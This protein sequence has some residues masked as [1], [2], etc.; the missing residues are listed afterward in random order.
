VARVVSIVIVVGLLAGT[1]A[2]FAVTERLKLQSS[3]ISRTKIAQVFSPTC[4]CG[5]DRARLALRV[6]KRDHVTLAI[7]DS[8]GTPVR[9]LLNDRPLEGYYRFGWDGRNGDGEIVPEGNYRLRIQLSDL[10]RTFLAPALIQVDTTAPKLAGVRVHPHVFSPD[11]DQRADK[12]LVRYRLSE[13]ARVFLR[14]NGTLR[15]RTKI[16]SDGG[17]LYWYGRSFGR[18][19]RTGNYRLELSAR[20]EAGNTSPPVTAGRV[21]LRYIQIQGDRL[22]GVAGRRI[23]AFVSTDAKSYTWR[24]GKHSGVARKRLLVIPPLKAG[25]HRLVVEERGHL[26]AVPVVVAKRR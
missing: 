17:K 22:E 5:T 6:A 3:P 10:G 11:G 15:V 1:A 13:P 25:R 14:T 12:V 24:V 16:R 7:V 21:R 9:T 20:D 2:A 4:N 8:Q 23:R 26:D 18:S 19:L